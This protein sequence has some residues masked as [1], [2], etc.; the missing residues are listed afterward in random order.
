MLDALLVP[1]AGFRRE[2]E[3]VG[4]MLVA[5]GELEIAVLDI[6]TSVLKDG[7][8]SA[9]TM[10]QLRSEANRLAVAEAIATPPFEKA[11]L[12]GQ[13]KEAFD[14]M[15]HCKNIRNQYAHC[16]WIGDGGILRFANLEEAAKSKGEKCQV[17]SH[18]LT[19]ALLRNQWAYFEYADH[20]LLWVNQE[21]RKKHKQELHG[22]I[23]P[24]PKRLSPPKQHSR[25]EALSQI[26]MSVGKWRLQ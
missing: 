25:G 17:V 19:L 12:G 13:F 2:R 26:W 8:A 3:I 9:R 22:P 14:A 15:N 6:L 24:K 10:F 1:F 18:P 23:I 20:A 7:Q 5:Y 4:K 11:G 21:Y 16:I